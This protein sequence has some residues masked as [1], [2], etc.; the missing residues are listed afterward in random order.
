VQLV[1]LCLGSVCSAPLLRAHVWGHLG[2]GRM[3]LYGCLSFLLQRPAAVNSG[4]GC[5]CFCTAPERFQH[6]AVDALGITSQLW[7]W[8]CWG[9]SWAALA[10]K[11]STLLRCD[12]EHA[13]G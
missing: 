2:E 9:C 8:W 1:A 5:F 7:A 4:V 13:P 11:A 10:D 6:R 3:Y 12:L